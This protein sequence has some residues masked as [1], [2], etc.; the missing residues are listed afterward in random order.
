MKQLNQF[1]ASIQMLN[2]NIPIFVKTAYSAFMTITNELMSKLNSNSVH[3]AYSV[4]K[5]LTEFFNGSRDNLFEPSKTQEIKHDVLSTLIGFTGDNKAKQVALLSYLTSTLTIVDGLENVERPCAESPDFYMPLSEIKGGFTNIDNGFS[6]QRMTMPSI[7]I[8]PVNTNIVASPKFGSRISST[9]VE[10]SLGY[11]T[12]LDDYRSECVIDIFDLFKL[13][14][15]M[16]ANSSTTTEDDN[17]DVGDIDP[18]LSKF[19]TIYARLNDAE[20]MNSTI[21]TVSKMLLKSAISTYLVFAGKIIGNKSDLCGWLY[22]FFVK[23]SMRDV[24][25]GDYPTSSDI[26]LQA[27][28]QTLNDLQDMSKP[29]KYS[30][31]MNNDSDM[32][33][34]NSSRY[35]IRMYNGMDPSFDASIFYKNIRLLYSNWATVI[36]VIIRMSNSYDNNRTVYDDETENDLIGGR[37]KFQHSTIYSDHI[38]IARAILQTYIT[39][40]FRTYNTIYQLNMDKNAGSIPSDKLIAIGINSITDMCVK[41]IVKDYCKNKTDFFIPYD[42]N[43]ESVFNSNRAETCILADKFMATAYL[44]MLDYLHTHQEEIISQDDPDTG[45][46]KRELFEEIYYKLSNVV[47]KFVSSKEKLPIGLMKCELISGTILSSGKYSAIPFD[48]SYMNNTTVVSDRDRYDK[49]TFYTQELNVHIVDDKAMNEQRAYAIVG[50]NFVVPPFSDSET[51]YSKLIGIN[52]KKQYELTDTDMNFKQFQTRAV[53]LFPKNEV[54]IDQL[55]KTRFNTSAVFNSIESV[56]D[57]LEESAESEW[58]QSSYSALAGIT[59]TVIE[60]E[61]AAELAVKEMEPESPSTEESLLSEADLHMVNVGDEH[62]ILRH[63]VDLKSGCIADCEPKDSDFV[64]HISEESAVLNR[65]NK[66]FNKIV[67]GIK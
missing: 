66:L 61:D 10:N 37:N 43:I 3:S 28:M 24:E 57:K 42:T 63:D 2:K 19:T 32:K 31:D 15:T 36:N 21:D 39:C 34:I 22:T 14:Y 17:A 55:V 26:T 27:R 12:I 58:A 64:K 1:E 59:P 29:N 49:T 8:Q 20:F 5:V 48:K 4:N 41:E 33:N 45:K 40:R 25:K 67:F 35:K 18:M 30:S 56:C 16:A 44:I 52:V 46:P 47:N 54:I 65:F 60:S 23:D 11:K 50:T 51:I 13:F 9:M 38:A 6:S 62:K 7:V 53:S